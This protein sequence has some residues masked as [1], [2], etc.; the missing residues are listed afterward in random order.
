MKLKRKR[1]TKTNWGKYPRV[2]AAVLYY[3]RKRNRAR[4]HD[5]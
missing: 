4:D 2:M 3:M 1:K 5:G